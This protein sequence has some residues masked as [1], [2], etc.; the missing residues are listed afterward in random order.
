[1]EVPGAIDNELMADLMSILVSHVLF[2]SLTARGF[3]LGFAS[4]R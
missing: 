2:V 1:M 3:L 4:V